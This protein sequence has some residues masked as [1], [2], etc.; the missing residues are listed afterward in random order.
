MLLGMATSLDPGLVRFELHAGAP[1]VRLLVEQPT[2]TSVDGW[3]LVRR[4]FICMITGPGGVQY[5]FPRLGMGMPAGWDEA[6]DAR[7]GA[8]V[9]F[10]SAADAGPFA[11]SI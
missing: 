9:L 2:E 11:Q 7:G 4:V 8:C 5:V 6:M 10:G 3:W 1:V